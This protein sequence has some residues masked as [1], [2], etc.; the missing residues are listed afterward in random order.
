MRYTLPE[1]LAHR[2]ED[3]RLAAADARAAR[4]LITRCCGARITLADDLGN[5][6]EGDC[7]VCHARPYQGAEHVQ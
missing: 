5:R 6:D 1:V 4:P 3:E 2:R 7:N